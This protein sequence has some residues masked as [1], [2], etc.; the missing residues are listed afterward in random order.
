L[1]PRALALSPPVRAED[2]PRKPNIVVILADD[3]DQSD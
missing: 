2:Q 3:W 1:L